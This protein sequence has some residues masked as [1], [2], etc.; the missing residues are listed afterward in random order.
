LLQAVEREHGPDHPDAISAK[1]DLGWMYRQAD[2][3][4]DAE[5]LTRD[6]LERARRVLGRD[7][8][9]TLVAVNNLAIIFKQMGRM[10][11]AEPL[12]IESVEA[13]KRT[14]GPKHPETVAGMVNLAGFYMA[15][16]RYK[17]AVEMCSRSI[18]IFNETMPP[19]FYGK[20]IA[21]RIRG[22]ARLKTNDDAG[23]E[24]DLRAAYGI[25]SKQ[26]G[27]GS[28][29]LHSIALLLAEASDHLGKPGEAAA[30]RAKAGTSN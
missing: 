20:G 17:E 22:E 13:S 9:Q 26:G 16:K 27:E 2:R 8:S 25:L 7:H 28:P 5:R 3:L 1:I 18:A 11:E 12:Y 10:A 29:R 24:K 21:F 23:A 4:E 14:L 15:A 30:W 19:D 6:A